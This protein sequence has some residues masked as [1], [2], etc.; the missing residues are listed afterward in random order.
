M[1]LIIHALLLFPTVAS[2]DWFCT[3]AASQRKGSSIYACGVGYGKDENGARLNAFD[4]AKR[5]FAR[6]CSESDDCHGR[7]LSVEPGRTTCG[8]KEGGYQCHRLVI[9]SIGGSSSGN[10]RPGPKP[11]SYEATVAQPKIRFG[12]KKS[13]VLKILGQ[14]PIVNYTPGTM[15]LMIT[16]P[17][18]RLSSTSPCDDFVV[19]CHILFNKKDRVDS[20]TGIDPLYTEALK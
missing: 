11:F 19:G 14:P 1:R 7:A 5:E 2:A 18:R 9:F 15:W 8:K 6:V 20:F 17:G 4:N 3:E 10:V 13:D 12:M 16:Y